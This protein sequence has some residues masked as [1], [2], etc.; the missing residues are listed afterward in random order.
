MTTK[1]KPN[2]SFCGKKRFREKMEEKFDFL[3]A[4]GL[5][6]FL[7]PKASKHNSAKKHYKTRGFVVF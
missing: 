7:W 5:L 3:L 1:R 4:L 2:T 6:A